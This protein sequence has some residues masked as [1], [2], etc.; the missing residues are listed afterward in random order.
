M[1]LLIKHFLLPRLQDVFFL[2]IFLM[3]LIFGSRM[4]NLDG[5]L[6]RHLAAGRLIL[7]CKKPDQE[8]EHILAY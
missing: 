3:V 5:D 4:L 7:E 1:R 6:P 2:V 8:C